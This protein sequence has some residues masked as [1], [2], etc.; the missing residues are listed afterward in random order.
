MDRFQIH[1]NLMKAAFAEARATPSDQR[2]G[3]PQPPLEKPRDPNVPLIDLPPPRDATLVDLS[4]IDLLER[5]ES[6]REYSRS[7]LSQAEL[8]FLLWATQGVKKVIR[9]GYATMRT[10]PSG[11]ARHPFETYLVVNRV[12]G[13]EPG[14]YRYIPLGH[15]LLFLFTDKDLAGKISS[16][17]LGQDFV[18]SSAAVFIW[19]VIPY[20]GEW[21][22]GVAAHKTMLQ[23]IGHVCQNLYL[24]CEAISAGTC[25]IGAYDQA[26][27]D[28]FLRLD[29]EDEFVV[30]AAPVGKVGAPR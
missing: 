12:T 15:K 22:Y 23:D 6:R 30:Y 29:G 21:R 16:A 7:P 11:G 13:L 18:G 2:R 27:M 9:D 5:R 28:A 1:R 20:R 17:C 26:M 3:L 4:F 14:V 19:S 10:V 25:A 8:S 24:A